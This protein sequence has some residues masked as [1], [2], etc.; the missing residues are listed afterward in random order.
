MI[1]SFE[2]GKYSSDQLLALM[3]NAN[4]DKIKFC[5]YDRFKIKHEMNNGI[6]PDQVI[7]HWDDLENNT[8]STGYM[9]QGL[10]RGANQI[11]KAAK[12]RNK[13]FYFIDHP[14]FF[15]SQHVNE[16]TYLRFVKND[17]SITKIT[18]TDRKRFD[19]FSKQQPETFEIKNWNKDG[20]KIL[21]LPPS[22]WLCKVLG[23]NAEH[24]LTN[25]VNEIKKHTDREIV[26][27]YKKINGVKNNVSLQEDLK[28]TFAVVSMQSNA[29]ITAVL[30]GIPSFTLF[31]KYSAVVPVSLQDLS[32]I[33]TPLYA[34][35][36]HEWLFNLCNHN[37]TKEEIINGDV[38]KWVA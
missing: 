2:M 3:R 31:D 13:D 14:Y 20:K 27:R 19:F 6:I 10:M 32:K 34:D 8:S 33:E 4:R 21:V 29:A 30:N 17:F 15:R 26:V 16:N 25:T 18:N 38:L 22:H 11:Y 37:F 35:N 28:N 9:F 24:L 23:I 36:R 7:H 12:D 1:L 5:K